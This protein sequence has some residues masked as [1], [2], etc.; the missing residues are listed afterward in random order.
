MH[1]LLKLPP[2]SD[3]CHFNSLFTDQRKPH[4][5]ISVQGQA[6][7][8]R[9]W[10]YLVDRVPQSPPWRWICRFLF[11]VLSVLIYSIVWSYNIMRIQF[12]IIM[13]FWWVEPFSL[14]NSL[15]LLV[16]FCHMRL[17]QQLNSM[18]HSLA[19]KA[20]PGSDTFNI[21]L[22]KESHMTTPNFRISAAYN[23]TG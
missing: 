12:K 15:I 4:G 11:R 5:H 7:Q 23:K 22:V 21:P 20:P 10:K 16:I 2:G 19:L 8:E 9:D 18:N 6:Y 3:T 17:Q 13:H 14:W 1:G